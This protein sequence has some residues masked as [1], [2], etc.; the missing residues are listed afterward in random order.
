M[1][2]VDAQVR[3]KS[4]QGLGNHGCAP[5]SMKGQLLAGNGLLATTLSDQLLGQVG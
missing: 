1:A 2:F 5:I 4:G 3:Q